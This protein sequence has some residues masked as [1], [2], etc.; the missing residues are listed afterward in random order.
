MRPRALIAVVGVVASLNIVV[1]AH[2]VAFGEDDNG[3]HPFVGSLVYE[4]RDGQRVQGCSGTLVSPTVFVTAGHCLFG[5]EASGQPVWATFDDVIDSDANG[6]VDANV[7]LHS[8]TP[9]VHPEFGGPGLGGNASDPHD[10]G[11]FVLGSGVSAPAYGQLPTERLLDTVDKRTTR[12]TA[13]G[14]GA[15]RDDKTGAFHSLAPGTR[16]K[17]VTQGFHSLTNAWITLSMNPSTGSGGTCVG[18]SG[19]PHFLGAGTSETR[20]VASVTVTGDRFCRA[21]DK[22]YR[23]DTRQSRSFLDDFVTVP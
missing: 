17:M 22:T 20:I 14:Y 11:V 15:V 10:L 3:R 7:T 8:G 23:L 13:V 4:L 9:H 21:M 5:V 2:A 16:R 12:F 18:D 19:G 1:A 6:I